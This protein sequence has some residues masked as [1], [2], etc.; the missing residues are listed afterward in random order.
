MKTWI[1]VVSLVGVAWLCCG[2]AATESTADEENGQQE[3]ITGVAPESICHQDCR[4][5][6][7][8]VRG[9]RSCRKVCHTV[10]R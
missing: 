8:I 4:Q 9:R 6:C 3:A 7:T 10:C 2:C 5:E 1:A